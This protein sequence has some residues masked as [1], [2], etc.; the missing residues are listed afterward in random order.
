M[1][2]VCIIN[3][4]GLT[5]ELLPHAPAI[6]AIGVGHGWKSPVPAVTCTSQATM[7]TGLPP[8]K[9]GIVGNGW[10]QRETGEVRFWQQSRALVQGE[11]FYD[12]YRTAQM[13]WWFN[14]FTTAQWSATPKPHY[15]CDGSKVF[16]IIDKTECN[17]TKELGPF[18]FFSFWGPNAGLP[19]SEWIANA[20]ALVMTKHQPEVTLCYLPHLDYDFQR[21]TN[22]SL[23]RV[24][25]V[26]RVASKVIEAAKQIGAIPIVVSEYGLTPVQRSVSINRELR[27]AGYLEVRDGPFGEMLIAGESKAFAV[28][29]HQVA[30]L[31]VKSP[32]MKNDVKRI[33]EQIPGVDQVVAPEELE[34]D[35][36][37][38]GDWIVLAK[39][40]AW[41]NYYYWLDDARAPDF[42]PT[43]DI[44]RK[45]GYD[46]VELFCTS[47][48]RVAWRLAQKKLGFRYRMDVIPLDAS[49]VGGSHGLSVPTDQ[50][51]LIVGP[52]APTDMK[53]FKSY[54]ESLL[55]SN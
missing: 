24:A 52:D 15:G 32:E 18:P 26:D 28:V 34:L 11:M 17:L 8:S 20:T 45:P 10:Y 53:H 49:L 31:Y 12:K 50:G 5:K 29:D 33:V 37:R 35:H 41:F 43:V 21:F 9:H 40:D 30:H 36:P 39:P 13:F 1:G 2:K 4:V 27:N 7:L 19:S 48:L 55:N 42:A 23:D 47:K 38:S 46:P 14:Q 22:P 51:A 6:S 3:V 16:D 54:V 25:E 44:H